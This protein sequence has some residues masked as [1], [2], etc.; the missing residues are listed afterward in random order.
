[1]NAE[2]GPGPIVVVGGGHSAFGL[3]GDLAL[4]GFAVRLLESPGHEEAV[5]PIRDTGIIRVRGTRGDGDARLALVTTDPAEALKGARLVL[6]AVPAYAH[7]AVA[8]LCA[9]HLA[10]EAVIVLMP[11]NAGGALAFRADVAS[12]GGLA[13]VVA[14][15]SSFVFACKKDAP[16]GVWIRG[17]K[18]GLGVGVLPA[19]ATAEV[20]ATLAPVYPELCPATDVLE[21]SLSNA[22][23]V[24]HPPA[25]LLNLARIESLGP[26]YS[27]FHEGMTR[28]VCRL[29]DAIDAE[30]LSVVRCLGYP[31]ETLL[32]QLT[33]FYGD[34]GFGGATYHEAVSTTPVHGAARPPPTPQ[35]RYFTEDVPYGLVPI[36]SIGEAL[37]L[38]LPRTRG[39]IHVVDAVLDT[40]S[41][42][43]GRTAERLGLAGLDAAGM[44]RFVREGKVTP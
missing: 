34:Q 9:P 38:R 39:L 10:P 21:T 6:V 3:A 35:H 42:A 18:Q 15:A 25:L 26:D 20:M 29:T 14:E 2:R 43:A 12:V 4:R 17:V 44:R 11:G 31:E 30:R 8:T 32:A 24:A 13:P 5:A 23:H 19:S 1:V 7:E 27:F 22:N 37:G 36:V 16:D 28:S 41:F 33:R 40:D